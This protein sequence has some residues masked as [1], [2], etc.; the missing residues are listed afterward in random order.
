VDVWVL[1]DPALDFHKVPIVSFMS[2]LL[3]S[4]MFLMLYSAMV[5][6]P[7]TGWSGLHG[8]CIAST[9]QVMCSIEPHK[10]RSAGGCLLLAL[11]ADI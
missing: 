7:Y 1:C 8:V 2:E 5:I 4:F 11:Y 6:M 9:S 3:T 10:Q